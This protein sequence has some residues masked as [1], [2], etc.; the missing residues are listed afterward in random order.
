[1]YG[2]VPP[3]SFLVT[4]LLQPSAT[5]TLACDDACLAT[6]FSLLCNLGGRGTAPDGRASSAAEE[7]RWQVFS[8]DS[9]EAIY[10]L[11]KANLLLFPSKADVN[12]PQAWTRPVTLNTLLNSLPVTREFHRASEIQIKSLLAG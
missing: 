12:L 4:S 6:L 1:M 8:K 9:F 2:N 10:P 7:L 5:A 3:P 11:G